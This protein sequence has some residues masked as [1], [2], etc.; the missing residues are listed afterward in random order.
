MGMTNQCSIKEFVVLG[1]VE[2]TPGKPVQAAFKSTIFAKTAIKARL[3]FF[4]LLKNQKKLKRSKVVIVDVKEVPQATVDVKTFGINLTYRSNKESH[5]IYREFRAVNN[6]DAV[7]TIS[8]AWL[9][10]TEFQAISF[11]LWTF[12]R[13]KT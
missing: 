4:K 1:C 10:R 9:E 5:N 8:K 3:L 13:L 11:K 2:Q 6:C 12:S 7:E